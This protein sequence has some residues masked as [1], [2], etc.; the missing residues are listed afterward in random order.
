MKTKILFMLIFILITSLISAQ[1][2]DIYLF[3]GM[4][5]NAA[6][7]SEPFFKGDLEYS[8][9]NFL[10]IMNINAGGGYAIN[11]NIEI[12]GLISF[13]SITPEKGEGESGIGDF[14]VNGKYL[15]NTENQPIV[16]GGYVTVPIGSEKIGHGNFNFGFY[17]AT[18]Y[19]LS[20]GTL[21]TGNL[22][23][24]FYEV[25]VFDNGSL[26][27]EYESTLNLGFG[28]IIPLSN[29]LHLIPELVLITEGDYVLLSC[30]A[31][32]AV[33]SIPGKLRGLIGLGL[34]DGAPDFQIQLGW[35]Y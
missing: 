34:D 35:L 9:Y 32:Y 6:I 4:F 15:F 20:G 10:S 5:K 22:G 7:S 2:S 8:D 16:G 30:G 17:G 28:S 31:D 1:N 18:Q 26:K 3:K 13:I 19:A 23:L 21:L 25:T 14:L 33:Q 27:D 11:Q 29:E 12:D 24:D